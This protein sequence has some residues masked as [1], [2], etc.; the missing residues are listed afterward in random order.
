[1]PRAAV[2]K[3]AQSEV[4]LTDARP[5]GDDRFAI[6]ARWPRDHFLYHRGSGA[7]SDPYLL[8]ETVRQA[9][10]HL[11]HRF[12]GVPEEHPFV[13]RDLDFDLDRPLPPRGGSPLPVVLDAVCV[14]TTDNPRRFGMRLEVTAY[15]GGLRIGRASLHWEAMA[16]RRY[17]IVRCR[18]IPAGTGSYAGRQAGDVMPLPP[19]AVGHRSDRDVLLGWEPDGVRGP[20]PSWRLRLNRDH[21]VLFDHQSDHV[22]GMVLLEAFRQ[23]ALAGAPRVTDP[24]PRLWS[25][26]TVSATFTAFGELGLPVTLCARA[27]AREGG[28]ESS[29]M[30]VTALQEGR[31]LASAVLRGR[32]TRPAHRG[33]ERGAAC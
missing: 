17:E 9:T 21:P 22:P 11:S 13:L 20:G 2:H 23:T 28:G 19:M 5:L 29:G 15:A 8:V 6:A 30:E 12:Y 31:T 14:R 24:A 26:T 7:P 3:A 33:F 27:A 4:L 1:M 32:L 25:L 16:P 18:N 10:I